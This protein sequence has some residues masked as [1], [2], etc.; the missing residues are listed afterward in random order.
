[1]LADCLIFMWQN[2]LLSHCYP[3]KTWEN[4][5]ARLNEELFKHTQS[6]SCDYKLLGSTMAV[7]YQLLV[8][9]IKRETKRHLVQLRKRRL[10]ITQQ[11]LD[12]FIFLATL[13]KTNSLNLTFQC[14]GACVC[15]YDILLL[16]SNR[17]CF[18]YWTGVFIKSLK[19]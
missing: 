8:K 4:V 17:F 12:S 11:C 19:A 6:P 16:H 18:V 13:G 15:V 10:N 7:W 5:K 14:V 1:M 2:A 3:K 9:K